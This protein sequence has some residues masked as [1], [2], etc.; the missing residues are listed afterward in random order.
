VNVNVLASAEAAD[1]EPLAGMAFLNGI[2]VRVEPVGQA[3]A[4]ASAAD[5]EPVGARA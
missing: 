4:A 2:P 5:V 3:P 1:L